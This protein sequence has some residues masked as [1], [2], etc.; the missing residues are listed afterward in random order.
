MERLHKVGGVAAV[1][2]F[3]TI[4]VFLGISPD[5]Q[6]AQT[7]L[8]LPSPA[9]HGAC[10]DFRLRG[11][12]V[13]SAAAFRTFQPAPLFS[14]S[15]F[16]P[17]SLIGLYSFNGEG[18]VARSLTVNFAG[19]NPF[20]VVDSGTYQLNADCSGSVNFPAFAETLSFNVINSRSIAIATTT[21]GESGGLHLPLQEIKACTAASL[22][23]VYIYQGDGLAA[24]QDP[25]QNPP[26]LSDGFFPVSFVGSWTFD[27]QGGVSRS[28]PVANFGG[29]NFGPYAD[30]GTY[31]VNS[32]CTAAATFPNAMEDFQ[33]VL[34][35]SRTIASARV[36]AGG[37]GLATLVKQEL[38]D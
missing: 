6:L 21:Q 28:L 15:A 11:A 35:N 27:G 7:A 12:Y 14:L 13:F 38:E 10:S 25:F 17:V 37:A 31:Q 29:A 30:S 8:A 4:S 23:G 18:Q 3:V 33:L 9:V 36:T 2:G 16:S 20:P 24:G 22:Q 26:L 34:I 5:W 19:G 1:C 32:D